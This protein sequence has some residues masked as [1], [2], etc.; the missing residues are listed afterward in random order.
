MDW[1]SN[2]I[3]TRERTMEKIYVEKANLADFSKFSIP[4]QDG[5]K[6]WAILPNG[7]KVGLVGSIDQKNRLIN[8]V[9]LAFRAW[10]LYGKEGIEYES[11]INTE[12]KMRDIERKMDWKKEYEIIDK[13]V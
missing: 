5:L 9:K 11:L 3:L 8:A 6:A 2:G 13:Q 7:E 1:S 10:E 4:N 12:E